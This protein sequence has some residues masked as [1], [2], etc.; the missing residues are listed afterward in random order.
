MGATEEIW[1]TLAI[2]LEGE[3]ALLVVVLVLSSTPVF[4]TL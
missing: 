2:F 3:F 1:H 4:T